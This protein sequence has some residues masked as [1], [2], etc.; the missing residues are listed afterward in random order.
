M[1]AFTEFFITRWQFTL[2][3]FTMLILLGYNSLSNVPKGE[4]PPVQFP[5]VNVSLSFAGADAADIEQIVAIPI[6]KALN[7]LDD[8]D[9]T[10]VVVQ[11][12]S[13]II[14]VDFLWGV[15]I[16]RAF[17]QASREVNAVLA[18]LPEG[19]S[20]VRIIKASPAVA[21][22]AQI[23]LVS[24]TASP[25]LLEALARDLTDIAER[26]AGVMDAE[27]WG[28]APSQVTVELDL[29]QLAQYRVSPLAIAQSLRNE[30]RDLPIG[31][32]EAGGRRFNI[33]A[34]GAFTSLEEIAR[35]PV[36]IPNASPLALA[37]VAK[38]YWSND[39]A[40]HITRFNGKRAVFVSVKAQAGEDI[41]AVTS[42]L[43]NGIAGFKANLPPEVA[44]EWG[45]RQAK[46]VKYRLEHLGRDFGIAIAL[47]LVTLLP[48]GLRA[49]FIVMMSIPL[50]L[51]LGVFA[52][53]ALGYTLNQLS[54][55][56]FVLALGLLVDD[57]I[58]VTENIARRLREGLPRREAAIEGVREI[59]VAVMGCTATLL[60]AFLPL[61]NLPEGPGA[62]IR[63]LPVAVTLTIFASLIV[64]LTIIP[65]LA[66]VMLDPKA[67]GHSNPALDAVMGIIHRVYRPVLHVALLRPLVTV[68]V[69]L[70]LCA[71]SLLLV[72]KV[73]FSLF[74]DSDSPYF[75]V[76]VELPEGSN[77]A[78]TDKAVRF[79]DET[80]RARKEV[81]WTYSNAGRGNPQVYYNTG[82]GPVK[83]N[84]G[85]IYVGLDKFDGK[86]TPVLFNELRAEFKS[87]PGARITLRQFENG[88]PLEAPIEVRIRGKDLAT[89]E[90]LA[91]EV[92]KRVRAVPGTRDVEN[93]LAVPKIDLDLRLDIEKAAALGIAPGVIDETLRIMTA[94]AEVAEIRDPTGDSYPIR[95]RGGP[96]PALA[97]VPAA[98]GAPEAE[99]LERLYVWTEAGTPV[100]LDSISAPTLSSSPARINRYQLER[101]VAILSQVK[102]GFL[103]S[104]VTEAVAADLAT[105]KLP[106][107]YRLE[108]GGQA[109]S[110]SRSFSG[111]GAAILI[112]IFGVLA[113]LLL[114]FGA[115][116]QMLVVAF[117]IPFGI[118]GGLV[119]LAISG[120]SLSFT[121]MVGF[122]ALIGIEIKNSI[123]LVDFANQLRK[124]GM[125][126]REAVERAG[127]MRFLP[128][129]LTS[130]TAIGGL[131]ALVIQPSKLYSPLAIVIIGGL[132]S[133]TLLARVVTPA[134]YLLL[135]GDK[136]KDRDLL[137]Q[138]AE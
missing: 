104:R 95:L 59:W 132:V 129:L 110:A 16:D 96:S 67:Q 27:I 39:E 57:S 17:D 126:A 118:L 36:R 82:S 124:K 100:R 30:G 25:R 103:T 106:P 26:T 117:V 55:S 74:P 128:V 89:L 21:A 101:N 46:Q 20:D 32:V 83:A 29:E 87:W 11:D 41:F 48:L 133:S 3:V 122:V 112:A 44:F 66:A 107:G 93:P 14:A 2:V 125:A 72:N 113:V 94:G 102:D 92:E 127:E 86:A 19:V 98:F 115:F 1:R 56:G 68:F 63:S 91:R 33:K 70:A 23:A 4:D 134:I 121:A 51:A 58:V 69:G 109:E 52:L 34:T 71:A 88:P 24:E 47:V 8:V 42:A 135:A 130:L 35:V 18:T 99:I 22:I 76:D 105:L 77:I 40:R 62:F 119:G 123:L 73:G 81:I 9:K 61:L 97:A 137:A 15:N 49:A 65:F 79:A 138:P 90:S 50:S 43:E 7:G 136:A 116:S 108:F 13:A 28:A 80:L 75:L 37:D 120:Y 78:E 53:G 31:A 64:S 38:I 111:L 6:E 10:Y 45:F 131:L 85:Q 114:E 12:G 54:I 84:V 60:L 5:G